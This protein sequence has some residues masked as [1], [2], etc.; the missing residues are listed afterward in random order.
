MARVCHSIWEMAIPLIWEELYD[1]SVFTALLGITEDGFEGPDIFMDNSSVPQCEEPVYSRLAYHARFIRTMEFTLNSKAWRIVKILSNTPSFN[2]SLV[3][4]KFLDIA[5][6]PLKETVDGAVL[7]RTF[8]TPIM[9]R[10]GILVDSVNVQTPAEPLR[11]FVQ[12]ITTSH[13]PSLQSLCIE[14]AGS[15]SID[16]FYLEEV[17][18][19]HQQ[20]QEVEIITADCTQEMLE[21]LKDLP[22]LRDLRLRFWNHSVEESLPILSMMEKGFPHLV[23]LDI[24]CA[25]KAINQVLGSIESEQ[26]E[27]FKMSVPW[28]GLNSDLRMGRML[29]RLWQFTELKEVELR[30]GITVVWED[31]EPVLA[32]R[33]LTRFSLI[34]AQLE[35]IPIDGTH[36]DAM[37]QA[38]PHLSHLAVT[39]AY[40]QPMTGTPLVKLADLIHLT[41]TRPSLRSLCISFD[42]RRNGQEQIFDLLTAPTETIPRSWC[43]LELLDVGVSLKDPDTETQLGQ[44]FTSWWPT[45]GELKKARRSRQNWYPV[46]EF[47]RRA[48]GVP[49][50]P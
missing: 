4:L 6:D 17:L 42:A 43:Q 13:L 39:H 36:L 27:A 20:L 9:T 31:I 49:S 15:S 18:R 12:A 26:M 28:A 14:S 11:S 24:R 45:L 34:S 1:I 2:E 44:L 47:V 22:V 8:H 41:N 23:R 46:M 5:V 7:L 38:W 30:L 37:A 19:A 29:E 35:W 21:I 25:L 33:G 16:P 48:A 3:K 32:C 50:F 40:H 10:I